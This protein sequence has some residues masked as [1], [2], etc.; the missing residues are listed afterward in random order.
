M[1]ND[2]PNTNAASDT[3]RMRPAVIVGLGGTGKEVV[4]L[5]REYLI[6]RYGTLDAVPVIAFVVIDTDAADS[7]AQNR[8]ATASQLRLAPDEWVFASI[9]DTG[10]IWRE[11]ENLPHLRDWLPPD[12][13]GLGHV[14]QGAKQI[15]ALGRLAFFHN[16]DAIYKSVTQA[17]D[18]VVNPDN[19]AMM[20]PHGIEIDPSYQNDPEYYLVTS[21]AGGTGAG[22]FLDT[23]FLL[24][25]LD[26]RDDDSPVTA[27][28]AMPDVF[29]DSSVGRVKPNAY[30][31]LKELNYFT[32]NAR[33]PETNEYLD[34]RYKGNSPW[35]VQYSEGASV[36]A[37]ARP[38]FRYCYLV[39][40]QNSA[41]RFTPGMRHDFFEML[42]HNIVLDF[43]SKLGEAKRSAR[44]NPGQGFMA[45]DGR[46]MPQSFCSFGLSSL[47]FPSKAVLHA[48]ANKLC[49]SVISLWTGS[50][51]G[52]VSEQKVE[53]EAIQFFEKDWSFHKTSGPEAVTMI[54]RL[55]ATDRDGDNV[56]GRLQAWRREES[57]RITRQKA[58]PEEVARRLRT[59]T[60][61]LQEKTRDDGSADSTGWGQWLRDLKANSER[62]RRELT[63]ALSRKVDALL[64]A[65]Y[66]PQGT[67]AFLDLIGTRLDTFR[68]DLEKLLAEDGQLHVH[69]QRK[70]DAMQGQLHRIDALA[71]AWVFDKRRVVAGEAEQFLRMAQER[72]EAEIGAKA[73]ELGERLLA[74]LR[75]DVG[76]LRTQ[77]GQLDSFLQDTA[78]R[79]R[80]EAETW[81]ARAEGQMVNGISLFEAAHTIQACYERDIPADREAERARAL[82]GETLK[83]FATGVMGILK[84]P[85]QGLRQRLFERA[86]GDYFPQVRD[87]SAAEILAGKSDDERERLLQMVYDR[88]A[89][90]LRIVSETPGYSS[91]NLLRQHFVGVQGGSDSPDVHVQAILPTVRRLPH[92]RGAIRALPDSSK[93][94]II[95]DQEM[96]TYPLRA[97]HGIEDLRDDYKRYLS[98]VAEYP[99][100]LSRGW[101]D[102]LPD[103]IPVALR[104]ENEA[105]LAAAVGLALGLIR[106]AE[107]R[108]GCWIYRYEG[109]AGLTETIKLTDQQDF[110][111]LWR[112]LADDY[113]TRPILLQETH[114]A[115]QEAKDAGTPHELHS[116]LSA[117]LDELA[118]RHGSTSVAYSQQ[119]EPI[120]EFITDQGL[121]PDN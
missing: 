37:V 87:I 4:T 72:Y 15:R 32:Y 44:D 118:D 120:R 114:E 73:A 96:Y 51:G 14:S 6:D 21:L 86:A 108:D 13:E 93:D 10:V 39:G 88:S 117:Y 79:F 59:T 80:I 95:I 62:R 49:G 3:I 84:V 41:V 60:S 42:A 76:D 109:E 50:L 23:A 56:I 36:R 81:A 75:K 115:A 121:A 97:V 8:S 85:K 100:H 113:K 111:L 94:E 74:A 31:A 65:D 46:G 28:L 40:M 90:F 103:P 99:L 61:E 116:K 112:A 48:C 92:L 67:V 22:M 89:P 64:D 17:R 9:P 77:L 34:P 58:D 47:R 78:T 104:I 107:E 55:L 66:G 26:H 5:I 30:A 63:T 33:A 43:S 119:H 16:Y 110:S 83:H 57:D 11:R 52:P 101:Q 70:R 38:P 45:P 102:E 91:S 24:K 71:S 35:R 29:L 2:T 27:F 7:E 69:V 68:A 18:K 53:T 98:N 54:A 82:A 105:R 12:L 19:A 25:S 20:S 1:T 106:P